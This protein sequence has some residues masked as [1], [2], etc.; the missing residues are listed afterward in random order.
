MRAIALL[1]LV[2]FTLS[3]LAGSGLARCMAICFVSD[4]IQVTNCCALDHAHQ[5]TPAAEETHSCCQR[6][7]AAVTDKAH[8]A[9][10][11]DPTPKPDCTCDQTHLVTIVPNDFHK[12]MLTAF[13]MTAVPSWPV[14]VSAP[15]PTDLRLIPEARPPP[16]L[17]D[18]RYIRL[19]I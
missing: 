11:V 17:C 12:P 6:E 19:L 9:H 5:A 16:G 7:D 15:T 13:V 14:L 1:L 18:L 4:A 3:Q 2:T 10:N 8:K